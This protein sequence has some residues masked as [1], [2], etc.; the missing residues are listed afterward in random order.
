M[1]VTYRCRSGRGGV[2]IGIA[3]AAIAVRAQGRRDGVGAQ[4]GVAAG[5]K[6]RVRESVRER[7]S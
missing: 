6:E 2:A 1:G 7:E 4:L 5:E 3:I